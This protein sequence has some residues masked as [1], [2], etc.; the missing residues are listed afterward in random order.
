MKQSVQ[1]LTVFRAMSGR[2]LTVAVVAAAALAFNTQAQAD[3]GHGAV[4][5]HIDPDATGQLTAISPDG[6]KRLDV[7]ITGQSDYI[8]RNPDGTLTWQAVEPQAAMTLSV[9]GSNEPWDT[10]FI[11]YGTLAFHALVDEDLDSTGEE[12]YLAVEGK[13][14]RVKDR[15]EWL[16]HVVAVQKNQEFKVLKIDL[17]ATQ[18]PPPRP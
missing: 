12:T 1:N 15:S 6:E 3:P 11:G 17:R 2:F 8:R 4:V 13:L 16:L 7:A 18:I 9:P 14:T 10:E 5:T